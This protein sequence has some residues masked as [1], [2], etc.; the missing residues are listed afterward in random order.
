L[1]GQT[2]EADVSR[3]VRNKNDLFLHALLNSKGLKLISSNKQNKN[4]GRNKKPGTG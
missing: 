4:S 2:S 3:I 1:E